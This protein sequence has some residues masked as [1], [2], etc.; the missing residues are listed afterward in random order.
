MLAGNMTG[1]EIAFALNLEPAEIEVR[2]RDLFHELSVGTRKALV[3]AA[4]ERSIID[5]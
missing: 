5:L 1:S 3:A 4:I 2:I